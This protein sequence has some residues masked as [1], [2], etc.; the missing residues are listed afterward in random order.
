MQVQLTRWGNSL[1]MRIPKEMAA[2]L[3][4]SEGAHVEVEADGSRIVITAGRPH[5]R[6][7]DLVVGMTHDE[8]RDAF[9][10]GADAGRES[11]E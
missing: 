3:G 9:D 4:L 5:Y 1:G 10:W 7:E 2:R 6:L 8:L 11:V